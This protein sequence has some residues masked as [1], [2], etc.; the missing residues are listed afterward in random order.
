MKYNMIVEINGG[1]V[2]GIYTDNPESFIVKITDPDDSFDPERKKERSKLESLMN[3][4]SL[5]NIM[6][7]SI[8]ETETKI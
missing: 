3:S 4:G 5:V 2:T 8:G 6:E 7:E 1:I